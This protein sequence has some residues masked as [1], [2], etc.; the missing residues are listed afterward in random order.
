MPLWNWLLALVAVKAVDAL[1]DRAVASPLAADGKPIDTTWD[2]EPDTGLELAMHRA[3]MELSELRS[4]LP[5]L[6]VCFDH[7]LEDTQLEILQNRI[8]R[9]AV[10]RT[11][12]CFYSVVQSGEVTSLE[13]IIE[14]QLRGTFVIALGGI[15]P[16]MDVVRHELSRFQS[17]PIPHIA[18]P[19]AI[20][21]TAPEIPADGLLR[22]APD[23]SSWRA[24]L[25]W[26]QGQVLGHP[27]YV[28]VENKRKEQD[29]QPQQS[30]HQLLTQIFAHLPQIIEQV[31]KLLV[32]RIENPE[33]LRSLSE[34]MICLYAER[35]DPLAWTFFITQA[36]PTPAKLALEFRGLQLL[37]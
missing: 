10:Q 2:N 19:L 15:G 9:L 22:L 18:A 34:P 28:M 6:Q 3:E 4:F 33:S 1:A 30:D 12:H 5:R 11:F 21:A 36:H 8:A 13:I 17:Q 23:R 25:P 20:V 31:V 37:R 32:E 29:I 7:G 14:H 26:D 16:A 27:I 24:L 35:V